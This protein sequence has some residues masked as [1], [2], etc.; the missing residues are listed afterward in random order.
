MSA[1]QPIE[2][3]PKDGSSVL[4]YA[5][6]YGAPARILVMRWDDGNYTKAPCW[7]TDVH[8]FV[9]FEPT[10]WQPLPQPPEP[11]P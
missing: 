4:C 6:I 11:H 7:R 2:T 9:Q 5:P 1:W 10:H 8:S 3:A